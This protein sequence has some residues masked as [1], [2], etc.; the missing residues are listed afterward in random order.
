MADPITSVAV[1]SPGQDLRAWLV[2]CLV[3]AGGAVAAGPPQVQSVLVSKVAGIAD[4]DI[5]FACR[6]RV[7]IGTLPTEATRAEIALVRLDDCAAATAR[8][9]TRPDGRA[10]AALEDLAY[11][12]AGGTEAALTL[13]FDR[14]VR[15]TVVPSAD[16]H[17]LRVRVE[18]PPGSLPDPAAAAT[19][20]P[21]GAAPALTGPSAAQV[22]RA[23]ERARQATAGAPAVA[24][25]PGL[26]VVNLRSSREPIS[27]LPE[28]PAG[29]V[30]Y[31]DTT[32]IEGREWYRLRLG[33]FANEEEAHAT[34]LTLRDRYPGAWVT[35][36]PPAERDAAGAAVPAAVVATTASGGGVALSTADAEH[37][38]AQAR[39]AIVDRDYGRAA[40]LATQ[41]LASTVP[42]QAADAREL[43]GLA[44]ERTGA[45][46]QAAAEYRRYL[47]DHPDSEG[48]DRVR[49]RLDAL[50][51]ARDRP[52]ESLREGGEQPR[53]SAWSA[54]GGVSQYY[55]RDAIDWGGEYGEVDRSG[56]FSDADFAAQR[57]GERFDFGSRATVSHTLD[58]TGGERAPGDETR[59]YNLY[60]DLGDRDHG[61]SG[62]LGRQTVRNQGALGRF[63]GLYA[64]WQWT[65]AWRF[66][67][68]AGFPVYDPDDSPDTDR[69]FVG[70]SIDALE[71]LD[72]LD[73]NVFA[74]FQEV[75]GINDRESIGA[76]LRWFGADASLVTSFDYDFGYGELNSFA[77]LGNWTVADRVTFNAML[78]RRQAPYLTTEIAL[79]DQPAGSIQELLLTYSEGEI[80]QLALDRSGTLQSVA[81]GAAM[82][83]SARFHMS[84]DLT[85]SSYDGT[86]AS[87]GAPE[88]P[89]SGSMSYAYLSLIGTSLMREGDVSVL[90]LRY[91]DTGAWRTAGLL[92]DTRVPLSPSLRL[93]PRLLVS[94]REITPGDKTEL[95]V[96]PGVRLLYRL[97]RRFQLELEVG[98]HFGSDET[99]GESSSPSG[100]YL[101]LGY[102]ADF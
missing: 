30:A 102:R 63:D 12:S 6:H 51:S 7:V 36:V 21:R 59:I 11:D 45:A 91:A 47:A 31:V 52:R 19:P 50:V 43:L 24:L 17:A 88:T 92:L 64:S 69:R 100:Y 90:G 29:R 40:T 16:L 62:R 18:I 66:N 60:M 5:R 73:V 4:V 38:L 98:S 101:N 87:G 75:D 78:D 3:L 23:E 97:A 70:F 26:H 85:A 58:T 32:T 49:Q 53:A 8:E 55:R 42:A 82:P 83:L 86:P 94:R 89:D 27:E 13:R 44:R 15:F 96:T 34:W 84:V 41:V 81:L 33:F 1:A 93:N 77:A 67:V 99:G 22:A 57:R 54:S 68:L 14:P 35:R 80:R 37:L 28:A 25:G 74:S 61:L 9:S 56:L 79:V 10:L 39:A 2:A 76:E 65:P 46:A 72:I 20:L 95:L 48:A 71:F